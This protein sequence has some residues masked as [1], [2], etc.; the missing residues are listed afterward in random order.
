MI[1]PLL[2]EFL[3]RYSEKTKRTY[4]KRFEEFQKFIGSLDIQKISD[5]KKMHIEE[6]ARKIVETKLMRKDTKDRHYS[7]VKQYFTYLFE[8]DILKK[9][10]KLQSSWKFSDFIKTEI[11][12]R[13]S[14]PLPDIQ[15]MKK[16]LL[17]AKKANTRMFIFLAILFQNGMR[18]GEC[19]SIRLE[20]IR[21]IKTKIRREGK[22]E[23]I[24]FSYIITG[25]EKNNMK[26]GQAIYFLP[27]RLKKSLEWKLYLTQVNYFQEPI[28][29]FQTTQFP[30]GYI[31]QKGIS[32]NLKKYESK[33]ELGT[34]VNPH[35]FRDVLNE[36]RM[37]EGCDPAL[38]EILI[39]QVSKGTNAKHYLKKCKQIQNRFDY[40][41][42]FTP[43]IL[44]GII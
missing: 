42:K 13:N 26:R 6:Y 15:D 4:Q 27:K 39:N 24:E 3:N 12:E 32:K 25:I 23:D 10:L 35:I 20:N 18:P 36:I 43:D 31:S 9:P 5:V 1:W 29:L 2:S 34:L 22:M 37:D 14:K 19:R 7:L 16:L 21:E 38:R 33:L 11:I 17:H 40:W 44:K 30:P 28:Y 8:N 41:E